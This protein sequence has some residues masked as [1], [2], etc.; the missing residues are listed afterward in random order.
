MRSNTK[1]YQDE[2]RRQVRELQLT[3][4]KTASIQ[5]RYFRMLGR[6]EYMKKVREG[7]LPLNPEIL[8]RFEPD[9]GDVK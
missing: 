5:L 6:G 3:T 2:F 9:D 8:K 4:C 7:V 1:K